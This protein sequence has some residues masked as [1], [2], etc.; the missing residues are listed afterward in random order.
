[1]LNYK[2]IFKFF[3]FLLITSNANCQDE[4][5]DEEVEKSEYPKYEIGLDGFFGASNIG[6]SFGLGPKFGFV[7]NENVVL[8]PTIRYQQSW[9]QPYNTNQNYQYRNFG[10]GFFLHGRYNNVIYGGIEAEIVRNKNT[11]IDTSAI[12]KKWVPTVF[13][14]G[15]F[16][17]EFKQTIRLNVGIYYDVINSINSPYRPSYMFTI[18]DAQTGMVVKRLP[19]LYRIS[20][21]FPLGK[22]KKNTDNQDEMEN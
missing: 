20:V 3:I 12:F 11:Y 10:G 21:F 17:R 8:G 7:V 14:C 5:Y 2:S 19:L 6:G 4:N 18:K 15:G 13:I 9:S 22:K 1:M 16:S